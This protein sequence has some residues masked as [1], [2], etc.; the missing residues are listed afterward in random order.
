[1]RLFVS[2]FIGLLFT[3]INGL[4]SAQQTEPTALSAP[5]HVPISWQNSSN[6]ALARPA[7][8]GGLTIVGRPSSSELNEFVGAW[9]SEKDAANELRSFVLDTEGALTAVFGGVKTNLQ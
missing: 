6:N 2:I 8:P 4:V 7:P 3:V 9:K 5:I 1:M